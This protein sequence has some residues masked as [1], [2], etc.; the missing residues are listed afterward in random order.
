MIFAVLWIQQNTRLFAKWD[1]YHSGKIRMIPR[2]CVNMTHPIVRMQ[3]VIFLQKRNNRMK[4]H[5]HTLKHSYIYIFFMIYIFL[6]II[7]IVVWIINWEKKTCHHSGEI[8]D[9]VMVSRYTSIIEIF[10]WLLIIELFKCLESWHNTSFCT[11][12]NIIEDV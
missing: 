6:V 1:M 4:Q 2:A 8:T 9:R 11:T 3:K 12:N 5:G 7:F 10:E